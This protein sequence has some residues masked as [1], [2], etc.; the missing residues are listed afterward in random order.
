MP[1]TDYAAAAAALIRI[2]KAIKDPLRKQRM[3]DRAAI[4]QA[5]ANRHAANTARPQLRSALPAFG[6]GQRHPD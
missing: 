2:A 3:L 1:I 6:D 4:C 5:E